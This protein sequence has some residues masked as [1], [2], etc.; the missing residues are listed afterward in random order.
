M[1]GVCGGTIWRTHTV[2]DD[3]GN[4][5]SCE[6]VITVQDTIL[7]VLVCGPNETHEWVSGARPMFTDPRVSDACDPNP[8]VR[9]TGEDELPATCPAVRVFRCTW[10][11]TDACGNSVSCSQI[12][13]FVDTIPPSITCAGPQT[14][15]CP[16]TPAFPAPTVIDAC[17]PNPSVTF[18]DAATGVCPQGYSVTRTWTA[19]DDCGNSASCTQ[20]ITVNAAIELTIRRLG[21][22]R[23]QLTSIGRPNETYRIQISTDLMNWTDLGS[24]RCDAAGKIEFT[25]ERRNELACRFYRLAAP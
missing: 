3:C 13:T 20:T 2:T 9:V 23:M 1:G 24:V 8:V 10:T 14:I 22:G 11:A 25:E 21:D 19:T 6:Q 4:S 7:P 17:D 12:I 16:A 15:E 5:S 18:S